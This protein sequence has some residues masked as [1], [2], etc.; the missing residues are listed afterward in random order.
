MQNMNNSSKK[1]YVKP[2]VTRMKLDQQ[3]QCYYGDYVQ[4]CSNGSGAN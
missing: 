2:E 1:L 3:G 4:P